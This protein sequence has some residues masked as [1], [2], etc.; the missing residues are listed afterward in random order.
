MLTSAVDSSSTAVGSD[1][2]L[3]AQL[4]EQTQTQFQSLAQSAVQLEVLHME[5]QPSEITQATMQIHSLTTFHVFKLRLLSLSTPTFV[6]SHWEVQQLAVEFL[7][8]FQA[9][10]KLLI[11]AQQLPL[12]NS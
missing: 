1:Q 11:Q 12:F 8:K 5:H 4:D 2:Q 3:I 6:K 9:G 10:V 7:L